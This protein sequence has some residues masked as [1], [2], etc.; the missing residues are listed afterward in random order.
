[1][2]MQRVTKQGEERSLEV[3]EEVKLEDSGTTATMNDYMVSE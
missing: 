1:M 3:S 2:M